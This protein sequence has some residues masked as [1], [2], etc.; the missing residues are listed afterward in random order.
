MLG[1][2]QKTFGQYYAEETEE[3]QKDTSLTEDQKNWV[4]RIRGPP[5]DHRMVKIRPQP[6]SSDKKIMCSMFVMQT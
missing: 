3:L 4:F 1:A 2:C 5:W 6:K